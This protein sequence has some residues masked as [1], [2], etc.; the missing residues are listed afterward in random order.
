MFAACTAL[1][2]DLSVNWMVALGLAMERKDPDSLLSLD[3]TRIAEPLT[4]AEMSP[5][6]MSV[7]WSLI[8]GLDPT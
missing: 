7:Y 2:C 4:S 6:F 5:R 3:A 8:L 1:L